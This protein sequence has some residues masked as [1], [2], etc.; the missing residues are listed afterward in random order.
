VQDHALRAVPRLLILVLAALSSAAWGR[1]L[2]Q[3][4]EA[5][6]ELSGSLRELPVITHGTS[7]DAFTNAIA[8]SLPAPT[9]VSATLF[10]NC[11]A[12]LT[13]GRQGVWQN[14]TRLRTRVSLRLTPQLSAEVVYDQEVIVGTLRTLEHDLTQELQPSTF[15]SLDQ[16]ID[17]FHF[18]GSADE[19]VWRHLLYRA[20]LRYEGDHA[21]VVIGSQRIPWGVGRLWSP[22]D[23]FNF[24]PP[25]AIEPD[26]TPGVEALDA[27]WLFSGFTYLEGVLAPQDYFPDSAYALR[28]H[29]VWRDT[30]YSAVAGVFR[31]APAGG[32]DMARNL[33]DT[34]A[35]L[36]TVY[37]KPQRSVWPIGAPAPGELRGF[38]QV[39]ASI[40]RN[41]DI[42]N[43]LYVL[44]E[45]LY[46]GNALGF[47]SGLAGPLLPLFEATDH[48]PA[49]VPA[50]GGPYVTTASADRLGGSQVVSSGRHE[51]GIEF[52]YDI[53]PALRSEWFTLYD[54]DGTSAAVVPTIRYAPYPFLELTL[55]AQFFAGRA[56]S[57]YGN[58]EDL[59]FLLVE[60]FF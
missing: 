13:V 10:P 37:T 51:S 53:F 49:N 23:R 15:V 35:R 24:I 50:V 54:W 17:R 28:L 6:L 32:V 3:Q 58:V 2:W 39:V 4:G 47:G 1:V 8:A 30:D 7:E 40:D 60:S 27:K 12:F 22:M 43:G 56:R 57:E 42:G 25:L 29:G 41:F 55:G 34:A 21:E 9:C 33:G 16:T 48:P 45:Y 20:S 59:G 44:A 14:L 46:N 31:D 5:S 18:G 52:G 11:P 36:E 38:W 26:Q 19:G